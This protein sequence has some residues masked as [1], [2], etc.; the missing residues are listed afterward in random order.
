MWTAELP[1]TGLSNGTYQIKART[2]I[3]SR[4]QSIYSP[5]VYVGVGETAAPDFGLR[6]DLN[7]DKKVNLVDFSILLFN[8]K[9]GDSVAD[10]NQDG[11]VNLQDFSIMLFQW[12]G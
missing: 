4:D 8:W 3:S 1:T 5:I 9:T 11:D 2:V 12:T 6:A 7:R 10:I